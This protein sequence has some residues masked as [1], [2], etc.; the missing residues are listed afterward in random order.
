MQTFSMNFPA[1]INFGSFGSILPRHM[2]GACAKGLELKG[3]V[4]QQPHELFFLMRPKRPEWTLDQVDLYISS[5]KTSISHPTL[6]TNA[7][8]H[9]RY[10][11]YYVFYPWRLMFLQKIGTWNMFPVLP[12][13]QTAELFE[14]NRYECS[15]PNAN[16]VGKCPLT[17]T[18]VIINEAQGLKRGTG[19]HSHVVLVPQPSDDPRDP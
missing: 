5:N 12:C 17:S 1:D 13:S 7:V 19:R 18:Q 10:G 2:P 16:L 9:T 11:S 4:P 6:L 8:W 15:I 3:H 14:G